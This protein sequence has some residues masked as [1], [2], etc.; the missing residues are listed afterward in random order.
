MR[1]AGACPRRL[2]G[3]F[4]A[5]SQVPPH[6]TWLSLWESWRRSRLRGA[7]CRRCQCEPDTLMVDPRHWGTPG[8]IQGGGRTKTFPLG[9]RW[10]GE[11][12]SD[13]GHS[14]EAT[15]SAEKPT[16]PPLISQKSKIFASFP[17][18]GSFFLVQAPGSPSG[19]AV[20]ESDGEGCCD[21]EKPSPPS[22]RTGHLSQRERQGGM[23][24]KRE[25]KIPLPL[26]V[27]HYTMYRTG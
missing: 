3:F 2:R 26:S 4:A 24:Q 20:T 9:G 10:P 21:T 27:L 11:A 19:R 23:P 5:H 25:R 14:V 15:T 22:V 17:R 16:F 7:A 6:P 12:G 18:G 13:E 1:R 8:S